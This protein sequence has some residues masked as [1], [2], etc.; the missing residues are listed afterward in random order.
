MGNRL[1]IPRIPRTEWP[2]D[3]TYLNEE[4]TSTNQDLHDYLMT[5]EFH[6]PIE[7][8][9][10]LLSSLSSY[11][12]SDPIPPLEVKPSNVRYDEAFTA[13]R[14]L[15]AK[16]L[17]YLDYKSKHQSDEPYLRRLVQ[18]PEQTMGVFATA[19]I[20]KGSLICRIDH[21]IPSDPTTTYDLKIND[22]AYY[23][24]MPIYEYLDINNIKQHINVRGIDVQGVKYL[25]AI[26]DIK[27]DEELL[28][29]YDCPLWFEP[30]E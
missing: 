16:N 8:K 29:D 14:K 22:L 28:L 23:D 25:Q 26:K 21:K 3:R 27:K 20:P 9:T 17:A 2:A 4:S 13:L 18:L 6:S 11:I 7:K 24:F 19:D 15:L 12:W 30:V 1:G 5:S 10:G